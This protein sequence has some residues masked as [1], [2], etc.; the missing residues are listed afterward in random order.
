MAKVLVKR[1]LPTAPNVKALYETLA[2][3]IAEDKDRRKFLSLCPK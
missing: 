3:E 1:A 2:G